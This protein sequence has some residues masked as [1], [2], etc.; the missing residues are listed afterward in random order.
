MHKIH[1]ILWL[2]QWSSTKKYCEFNLAVYKHHPSN[3]RMLKIAKQ[4]YNYEKAKQNYNYA[5]M[6][7]RIEKI[8]R[9]I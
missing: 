9:K 4:N 2:N 8:K 5:K 6:Q 7:S 3:I 1:A